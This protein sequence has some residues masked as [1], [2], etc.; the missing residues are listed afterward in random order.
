[1]KQYCEYEV[2]DLETG[3]VLVHGNKFKNF[4]DYSKLESD[5]LIVFYHNDVPCDAFCFLGS[6]KESIFSRN[7]ITSFCDYRVIQQRMCLILYF[8]HSSPSKKRTSQAINVVFSAGRLLRFRGYE[9][10][11]IVVSQIEAVS[12]FVKSNP[13]FAKYRLSDTISGVGL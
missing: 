10:D 13:S 5:D 9:Y 8:I 3:L 7:T 1:M 11:N 12:L 6:F 4:G 2:I